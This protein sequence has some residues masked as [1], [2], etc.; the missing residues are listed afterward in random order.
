MII[1]DKQL[2]LSNALRTVNCE[3]TCFSRHS[4]RLQLCVRYFKKILLN[5]SALS[6]IKILSGL[7]S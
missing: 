4:Q 5:T 6:G 7:T 2:E 1:P 3:S